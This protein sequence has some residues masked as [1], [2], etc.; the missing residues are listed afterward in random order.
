MRE[1]TVTWD[2]ELDANSPEDAVRQAL[3]VTSQ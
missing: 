2:I 3:A 1:Y